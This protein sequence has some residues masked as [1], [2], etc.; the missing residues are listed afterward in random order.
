MRFNQLFRQSPLS[1]KSLSSTL[2]I[3]LVL[4][5]VG[6]AETRGKRLRSAEI[7]VTFDA[8]NASDGLANGLTTDDGTPVKDGV[9]GTDAIVGADFQIIVDLL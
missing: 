5:A 4:G 3:T 2:A 6:I 8:A 1:N 7:E 9:D